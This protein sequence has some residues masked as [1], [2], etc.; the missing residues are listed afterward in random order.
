MTEDAREAS[1][2]EQ[3]P[4]PARIYQLSVARRGFERWQPLLLAF[5]T[6]RVGLAALTLAVA[7]ITNQPVPHLWNHWD[8]NWYV[9]IAAH[10]YHWSIR[11]KPAVAFFPLY[12]LLIHV[13]IWL[14]APGIITALVISN[15][16]FLG[17]LYY[18]YRL[19]AE[20]RGERAA[21]RAVWLLALFPTAFFTFGPY[22]ESIFLLC[23]VA[24]LYYARHGRAATSSLWL[25]AVVLTRPTGFILVPAVLAALYF[26]RRAALVHTAPD[27]PVQRG[28]LRL[29]ATDQGREGLW[30]PLSP[31][32]AGRMAAQLLPMVAGIALYLYYLHLARIPASLVLTAQRSWHRSPTFPWAGFTSSAVWL[33]HHGAQ[34]LPWTFENVVEGIVTLLCLG[35]TA[36]AMRRM[37]W[38]ARLYCFGF[39][40][41]VLTTPEWRNGYHAPF[42]SVDRFVLTLFPVFAWAAERTPSQLYRRIALVSAAAMTGITCAYLA[43]GWV[44]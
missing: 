27:H 36:L 7:M 15:A 24:A 44:G 41:L 38:D 39:W 17:A 33:I 8:G 14:N 2:R 9:G 31:G 42:T 5:V 6:T 18:L 30:E 35:L 21:A 22:S 32:L 28:D 19:V 25:G 34:N 43:G 29:V 1:L 37:H 40:A 10:G 3:I 11:G 20:E 13:G 4:E 26:H 12:P 23:A 16:A